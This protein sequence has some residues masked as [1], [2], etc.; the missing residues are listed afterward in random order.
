MVCGPPLTSLGGGPTHMRNLLAS[1]LREQFDLLHFETGSRGRESPAPEEGALSKAARLIGSPFVLLWWLLRL[2]PQIVHLNSALDNKAFW[3]DALY[4]LVSKG[5]R[6]KVVLQFHGGV[7]AGRGD[8]STQTPRVRAVLALPDALVM[9]ASSE[10]R[11]IDRG[12]IRGNIR[13]IPNCIDL[14]E[15]DAAAWRQHSGRMLRFAFMARLV[16]TKGVYGGNGGR[17]AVAG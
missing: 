11:D 14:S 12:G 6:R 4:V 8:W 2:R 5:F 16:P 7:F 15:F 1:P 3:R 13:V 17:A 10:L 9:L